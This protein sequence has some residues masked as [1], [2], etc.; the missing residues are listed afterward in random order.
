MLSTLSNSLA[1]SLFTWFLS[2]VM[3]AT[4]SLTKK[5][6][7]DDEEEEEEEEEIMTLDKNQIKREFAS[8]LVRVLNIG[9][10]KPDK[11]AELLSLIRNPKFS[12]LTPKE[13]SITPIFS[14]SFFPSL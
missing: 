8:E 12:C 2:N 14:A 5:L 11:Q 9:S 3:I 1:D 4:S 7:M 13:M 6:K 10:L